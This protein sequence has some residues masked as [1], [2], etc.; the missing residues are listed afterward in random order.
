MRMQFLN[1]PAD[2]Q[3]LKDGHLRGI[4]I[5][6]QSFVIYG[7]ECAPLYVDLYQSADPLYSD[8]Y[9]RVEFQDS[10]EVTMRQGQKLTVIRKGE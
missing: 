9:T 4:D 3:W 8:T 1:D 6:F 7:N 5:E 10:G 2:V